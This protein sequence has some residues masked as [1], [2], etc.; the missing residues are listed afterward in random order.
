MWKQLVTVCMLAACSARATPREPTASLSDTE[1]RRIERLIMA[2]ECAR[3]G[4]AR[5]DGLEDVA[6][7][8]LSIAARLPE[9]DA[10]DLVF[11]LADAAPLQLADPELAPVYE[12]SCIDGEMVRDTSIDMNLGWIELQDFRAAERGAEVVAETKVASWDRDV[13]GLRVRWR[14]VGGELQLVERRS[15]PI[16]EHIGASNVVIHHSS[17]KWRELDAEVDARRRDGPFG[18]YLQAL[19]YARRPREILTAFEALP[20]ERRLDYFADYRGAADG[21]GESARADRALAELRA[22]YGEDVRTTITERLLASR[23]LDACDIPGGA[24]LEL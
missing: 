24:E 21:I 16:V 14:R 23:E 8:A 13:I 18:C 5:A 20:L 6:D 10:H 19:R 1:L 11:P 2:R 4:M 15:W 3:R 22:Q 12:G 17:A 9:P 7:G